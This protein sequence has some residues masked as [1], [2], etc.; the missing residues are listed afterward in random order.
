MLNAYILY[1]KAGNKK[2]HLLFRINLVNKIIAKSHGQNLE[3]RKGR[4]S[5]TDMECIRLRGQHFIRENP[6]TE[7]YKDGRR[8]C[9]VLLKTG[10]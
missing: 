5:D 3:K 6:K 7:T 4:P 10:V 8:R 9:V 2:D 1:C